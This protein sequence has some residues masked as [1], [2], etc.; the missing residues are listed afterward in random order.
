MEFEESVREYAGEPLT[1]Q[2]LMDLLKD[3]QRPNDKISE[4][5][6]AGRLTSVK[7]GLYV[8]GPKMK[9]AKPEPFLIANHLRGPSYV[10]LEAALSYWGL[11]PERVFEVSSV[12]TKTARTYKTQLGNF[13]Y[14]HS[15]LPYYAFGVKSVSLSDRQVVLIAS[16]E[17]ALCDKIIQTSGVLLRSVRQAKEF[18]LDDLRIDEES[19]RQLNLNAITSWTNDAPKKSSIAMLVKTLDEL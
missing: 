1:R 2:L 19:L 12:T 4:L 13:T 18:L 17:K 9:L 14:V 15:P 3:Y 7:N 10:S 6:K 5:I 8:T 16:P 11:I